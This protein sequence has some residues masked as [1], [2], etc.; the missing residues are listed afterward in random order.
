V[1]CFVVV[2]E[3]P[4]VCIEFDVIIDVNNSV[5]AFLNVRRVFNKMSVRLCI[6]R[7]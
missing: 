5:F 7:S 2:D 6:S 4:Y 3:C 1:K